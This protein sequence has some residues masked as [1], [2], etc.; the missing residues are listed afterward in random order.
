MIDIYNDEPKLK[1]KQD[2]D[3]STIVKSTIDLDA[4][5]VGQCIGLLR[6]LI[7]PSF[8]QT[9]STNYQ[10]PAIHLAL[11]ACDEISRDRVQHITHYLLRQGEI[12]QQYKVKIYLIFVGNVEYFSDIVS[13]CLDMPTCTDFIQ[14]VV[15]GYISDRL[16][17]YLTS[18]Q[19][20]N[21]V[22]PNLIIKI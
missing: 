1:R 19:I 5:S 18:S 6:T 17:K 20:F 15:P 2:P 8:L 3:P 22:S 14:L 13:K 16:P 11:Y 7:E 10:E 4:D 12:L 21:E 9:Y